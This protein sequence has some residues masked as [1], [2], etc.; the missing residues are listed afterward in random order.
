[1][2]VTRWLGGVTLALALVAGALLL[3]FLVMRGGG[4][5]TASLAPTP[6]PSPTL[7]EALL[8]RRIT[9][10][11]VGTDQNAVRK[12]RG[13]TPLTDSMIVASLN[14]AH[15][16]MVMISVPRDTVRV[17]LPDG[18][19]W[20]GKLNALY[21]AKGI[22]VL[23]DTLGKLLGATID[24][25]ILIEMD[26]LPRIVDAFGGVDVTVAKAIDDPSI[27]LHISA[28]PH[29]LNGATALLYARSRHTTNDFE[30]AARQ[31]QILRALLE[32]FVSPTAKIDLP[33]LLV[34]LSGL[35]TDIPAGDLPTCA[36]LARRARGASVDDQVLTPPRF[37]RVASDPTYGY[38]LIPD[39]A[40][41]RSFAEPLLT[42]P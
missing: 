33:A 19:I 6:S 8:D 42:G 31:Q 17:P 1:M 9:I 20:Q 22:G 35:Q 29:H 41:I 39:L 30:R 10:L 5:A 4:N 11:L 3:A 36:E 27:G 25:T 15:T 32:R 40:A 7:D 26:D 12:A 23:R 37:Y 14:A 38:V 24:R 16:R 18:T 13:E 2:P 34:S 28:G 21:Q